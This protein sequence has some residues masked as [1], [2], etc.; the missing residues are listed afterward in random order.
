MLFFPT[1]LHLS[2]QT[3][4][5]SLTS[6][7]SG[8]FGSIAGMLPDRG[9]CWELVSRFSPPAGTTRLGGWTPGT[10]QEGIRETC[11]MLMFPLFNYS[12]SVS[13]CFDFSPL[14]KRWPG[15]RRW[16]AGVRVW[17]CECLDNS[18]FSLPPEGLRLLPGTESESVDREGE[19][20]P[21]WD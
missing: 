2:E 19:A 16:A 5:T 13:G 20:A 7:V 4:P 12:I 6:G 9:G 14:G 21:F 3:F 18:A 10:T 15:S 11:Q 17:L 1:D 8:G